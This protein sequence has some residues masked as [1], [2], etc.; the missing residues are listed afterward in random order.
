MVWPLC[1][2]Y[3]QHHRFTTLIAATQPGATTSE[4][5]SLMF[6]TATTWVR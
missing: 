6:A 4:T 3:T 5:H 2:Y 1:Q